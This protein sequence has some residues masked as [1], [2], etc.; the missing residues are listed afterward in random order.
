MR[1][2]QCVQQDINEMLD[3]TEMAGYLDGLYVAA[4]IYCIKYCPE[5]VW[6]NDGG[7]HEISTTGFAKYLNSKVV[8]LHRIDNCVT[9]VTAPNQEECDK[10]W[11]QPER[12]KS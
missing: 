9:Q 5:E 6:V 11:T 12:F 4:N 2:W 1:I 8:K 10:L 7:E 3:A